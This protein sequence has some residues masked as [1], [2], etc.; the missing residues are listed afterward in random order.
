[1]KWRQILGAIF[2][3]ALLGGAILVP[4]ADGTEPK[5]VEF[6]PSLSIGGKWKVEVTKMTEAPSLP[7]EL[8]ASWKPRKF[9][10]VYQFTV[11]VLE[12]IDSEP[13]FRLRIDHK[14]VDGKT[15]GAP[16]E[17]WRIYLRQTDLTLKKVE[18]LSAITDHVE[19]SRQ[20]E[21]GPVDA[22]DWVGSLPLA[23]PIFQGDKSTIGPHIRTSKDGK[24]V[25]KPS[26][27]C[28]QTEEIS[29]IRADGKEMDAL[30]ITL[31]KEGDDGTS[32]R[33]TQTWIKGMPWWTET[34][35]DRAGRQWCSA[36]LLKD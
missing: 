3:S 20:F 4:T 19:A 32:R 36:R 15:Y 8:I 5:R 10:V 27:H 31:E 2:V 30:K 12:D 9:T 14:T 34:T 23:F 17:Y 28:R 35:H 21:F 22:T 13:C 6:R 33:T 16:V 25:F 18:R 24:V 29:R 1:M 7:E 26:D 11:E